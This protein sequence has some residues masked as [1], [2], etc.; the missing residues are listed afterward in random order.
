[1]S[2][3]A[4]KNA[5]LDMRWDL[6][7]VFP[8][9]SSSKEFSDFREKLKKDIAAAAEQFARLP[10]KLEPSNSD[11]CKSAI[12]EYQRLVTDIE[13]VAAFAECLTAQNVDDMPALQIKQEID[14]LVSDWYKLQTRLE[15][16]ARRQDDTAWAALLDDPDLSGIRFSLDE[17]RTNA[18]KKMSEEFEAFANELAVS[19]YHAWNRLYDKIAGDLR[20]DF[21]ENG[22][23]TEISLGQLA[24]KMDSSER[25]IRKQAFEKLEAAWETR[26]EYAAM[27]LNSLAG[28]RLSLYSNRNWDSILYEPLVMGR[29]KEKTIDAMWKAV[30]AGVPR[31]ERYI[32]TKKKLLGIDKFNWYDQSAPVGESDQK[33][34]WDEAKK[35]I[36]KHLGGFSDEMAE[37]SQMAFDK[38]WIE[39][40]NRSGKA[41]GGFC[42][43]FGPVKESRIFMTYLDTFGDMMTLAHEL[44]HA[45]HTWVLRDVPYFAAEYPANLAETASIFNELLV[46]D[47][48]FNEASDPD[49]KLMLL[50]QKLQRTH[51]MFCNL[52][53]RFIFDKAFYSER[54]K[55]IVSR[56]RLDEIMVDAQKK[57]FGNTLDENGNHPLF[58]ASKLHFFL[59][60]LPF[61]NF[62]YTFG[63]LFAGGVY[64]RART[65]GKG[66]FEKYRAL[67]HDTGSMTTENLAQKH[68]GVDLTKDD[69]WTAAVDRMLADVEPFVELAGK[70]N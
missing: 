34:S 55:G 66:F 64:D 59:T 15:S 1:M 33:M 38:R 42:T 40:E 6:D 58:W 43:G 21:V 49:Q 26:A 31:L 51:V 17:L 25:S 7:S 10:D 37:F 50:D 3:D 5:A 20:V 67:L 56:K 36:V 53:A 57:A 68:L 9:G 70:S 63:F 44:G 52:Q 69:F 54:K 61:Y 35:F 18:R 22:K 13:L 4:S 48:A 2:S 16:Y 23:T 24:S 27:I 14:V 32:E 19:G 60:G 65:E 28:F 30:A 39:A 11:K 47:A 46:T 41:G 12:L 29:L 8:G 62:P 45:W